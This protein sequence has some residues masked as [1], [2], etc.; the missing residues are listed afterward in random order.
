MSD[1][2]VYIKELE[3]YLL[4]FYYYV[5]YKDYLEEKILKN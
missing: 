4:D 2:I 1:N 3:N 5:F